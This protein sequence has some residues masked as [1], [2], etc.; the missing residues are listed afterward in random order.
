MDVGGVSYFSLV[1]IVK[2]MH[3]YGKSFFKIQNCTK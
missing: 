1:F 2:W 3:A